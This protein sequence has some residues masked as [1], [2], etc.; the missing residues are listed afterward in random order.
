MKRYLHIFSSTPFPHGG[1]VTLNTITAVVHFESDKV[2][3]SIME[4]VHE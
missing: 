4:I 2:N 1:N 3:R